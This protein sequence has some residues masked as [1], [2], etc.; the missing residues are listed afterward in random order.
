MLQVD[1]VV[2]ILRRVNNEWLYGRV[3]DAEGMFPA[4]F[5]DIQVPLSDDED[6]IATALYEFNPETTEDLKL[7]VSSK[8][9]NGVLL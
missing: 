8:I 9:L 6:T 7:V 1:D 3:G 5:I 2:E 4:N